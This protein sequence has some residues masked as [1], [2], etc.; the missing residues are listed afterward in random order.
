MKIWRALIGST[1]GSAAKDE[2]RWRFVNNE[3]PT[4]LDGVSVTL[5]GERAFVY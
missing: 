1:R 2:E 5:N 3:L 4:Q